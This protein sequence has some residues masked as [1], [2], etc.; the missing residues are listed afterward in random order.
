MFKIMNNESRSIWALSAIL[1]VMWTSQKNNL[2][3]YLD[4]I[5]LYKNVYL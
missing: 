1:H 2:A 5:I 4:M 3:F